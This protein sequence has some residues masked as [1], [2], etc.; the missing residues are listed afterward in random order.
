MR[1]VGAVKRMSRNL[2][3]TATHAS[4]YPSQP[5][6]LHLTFNVPINEIDIEKLEVLLAACKRRTRV[7]Q[8]SLQDCVRQ[9]QAGVK[10]HSS[11]KR[12]PAELPLKI[13]IS[14]SIRRNATLDQALSTLLQLLQS[15]ARRQTLRAL[16]RLATALT[17]GGVDSLVSRLE[18]ALEPSASQRTTKRPTAPVS[19]ASQR[20]AAPGALSVVHADVGERRGGGDDEAAARIAA[21]RLMLPPPREHA[22]SRAPWEDSAGRTVSPWRRTPWAAGGALA[23]AQ[24]TRKGGDL[25]ATPRAS[26]LPHGSKEAGAAA[27]SSSAA[28]GWCSAPA[29]HWS[30][31]SPRHPTGGDF[32]RGAARSGAPCGCG[33]SVGAPALPEA[34]CDAC[35]PP[36]SQALRQAVTPPRVSACALPSHTPLS[37]ATVAMSPLSDAS[38]GCHLSEEAA[39]YAKARVLRTWRGAAC[40]RREWAARCVVCTRVLGARRLLR[41]YARLRTTLVSEPAAPC[42]QR[43][44]PRRHQ[45]G[46]EQAARAHKPTA[47]S[48]ACESVLRRIP[49]SWLRP[50]DDCDALFDRLAA[51]K[52]AVLTPEACQ[53]AV[54]ISPTAAGAYASVLERTSQY[55]VAH[56][57]A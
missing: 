26:E 5:R 52:Q 31:E 43:V 34:A 50:P 3:C 46:L 29:P 45:R 53:R 44:Q 19:T 9:E 48:P 42:E 22:P 6:H 14:R 10:Q 39:R 16:R 21:S 49:P 20:A 55:T 41:A 13:T 15:K 1:S 57:I 40:T 24:T 25:W 37:A 11:S 8:G 2:F 30:A 32:W 12:E 47:G 36:L 4:S 38:S 51:I 28:P 18:K 56:G 35:S 27:A 17:D 33:P 23:T 54:S 7:L